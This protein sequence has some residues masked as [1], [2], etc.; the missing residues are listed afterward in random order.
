MTQS[1]TLTAYIA[2]RF[3][4]GIAITLGICALLIFMIDIVELLRLS[5]K[6]GEVPML[7]LT[8]IAF[9]RLPAYI[10]FLF[11]FAVLVGSI[12]ALMMLNRKNEL[13]V[14]RAGGMSVWQFLWPGILVGLIIGVLGMVLYNPLAAAGRD[15]ADRKFAKA[16]GS[17]K[18]L[19]KAQGGGTW[20][21]QA[22]EDGESVIGAAAAANRGLKLTGVMALTYDR[23]GHFSE[24]I[25]AANADLKEGYWQLRNGWVTRLGQEP[26]KF[27][28]YLISTHLTPDR[29]QDALGTV[30]SVSFWELPGLIEVTEKAK[31][32]SEKLRIQYETLWSRPLLCI[33]MVLLAATVSL[34]SFRSGRIQTMVAAGMFGGFGF[35]LISEISRQIGIAGLAPAWAAVWLPVVLVLVI[36]TTVLLHQED[37]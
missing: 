21:R 32:S 11:G 22:G 14:M 33:A 35:F 17:E 28:T 16:F 31:L 18:N 20:L 7:A 34:K 37:G 19:L 24:R 2:K 1:W 25:D 30:L 13:A 23:D 29:V 5:G 3:L 6:T 8:E 15:S 10:E 4:L 12:G 36:S 26:E 9:L 27:E